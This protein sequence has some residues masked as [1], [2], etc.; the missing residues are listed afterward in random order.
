VGFVGI[1]EIISAATGW[2]SNGWSNKATDF[3]DCTDGKGENRYLRAIIIGDARRVSA[4][5]SPRVIIDVPRK[6]HASCFDPA[7]ITLRSRFDLA[8]IT[9]R[10]R[11][12]HALPSVCRPSALRP[13]TLPPRQRRANAPLP[14]RL[15][16]AEQRAG[17]WSGKGRKRWGWQGGRAGQPARAG[18]TGAIGGNL[19]F[20]PGSWWLLKR[21]LWAF[22]V[23]T[24]APDRSAVRRLGLG[25]LP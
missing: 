19:S 11:S 9:L 12:D 1:A 22:A 17:E 8:L 16:R 3:S 10:S 14:P 5:T 7:P 20:E 23:T 6:A 13:I 21:L 24:C 15:E 18:Q 2:S 25:R 4:A